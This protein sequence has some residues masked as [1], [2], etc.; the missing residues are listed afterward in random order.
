MPNLRNQLLVS[1]GDDSVSAGSS[2]M[3]ERESSINTST[4]DAE[5]GANVG[6]FLYTA[7]EGG[8]GTK[9]DMY[10]LGILL[11]EMCYRFSTKMERVI[12]LS[13]I[14]STE[15]YPPDF[16]K[17]EKFAI[18][19]KL[20]KWLLKRTPDDRPTAMELLNG[21]LMPA[22]AIQDNYIDKVSATLATPESAAFARLMDVLFNQ[23]AFHAT[24]QQPPTTP[25]KDSLRASA[26]SIAPPTPTSLSI[27]GQPQL[28]LAI[29]SFEELALRDS[30]IDDM[31]AVFKRHGAL[32]V[33]LPLLDR[34]LD[35]DSFVPFKDCAHVLFSSGTKMT[36]PYDLRLAFAKYASQV[37][38]EDSQYSVRSRT[39]ILKRYDSGAVYRKSEAGRHPKQFFLAD[40]DIVLDKTAFRVPPPRATMS[41]DLSLSPIPLAAMV[42][43]NSVFRSISHH[44][45]AHSG[46]GR[47]HAGSGPIHPVPVRPNGI[48][49]TMHHI[50]M[51]TASKPSAPD[52]ASATISSPPPVGSQFASQNNPDFSTSMPSDARFMQGSQMDTADR[53]PKSNG[54]VLAEAEL[55]RVA[56]EIMGKFKSQLPPFYIRINS[57]RI[58]EAIFDVCD[59]D[60]SSKA[61]QKMAAI[62]STAG[63]LPW[64][65]VQSQLVRDLALPEAKVEELRRF[66]QFKG[67]PKRVISQLGTHFSNFAKASPDAYVKAKRAISHLF[68]L[69][70]TL[71]EFS[72]DTS[73]VLLFDPALSLTGEYTSGIVFQVLLIMGDKKLNCIAVGGRYDAV[74]QSF[75]AHGRASLLASSGSGML[76]GSLVAPTPP[77]G[78]STTIFHKDVMRSPDVNGARTVAP[79][80]PPTIG[81]EAAPYPTAPAPHGNLC[82]VGI[83]FA[84]DKITVI[85]QKLAASRAIDS[86]PNGTSGIPPV[87]LNQADV[88][89]CSSGSLFSE[90]LNMVSQFWG[91]DVKTDYIYD[92]RVSIEEQERIAREN[93][94]RAVVRLRDLNF[95]TTGLVEIVDL[96]TRPGEA[97]MVHKNESGDFVRLLLARHRARSDGLPLPPL[98]HPFTADAQ[99]AQQQ[100]TSAAAKLSSS[101]SVTTVDSHFSRLPK[102]DQQLR[103]GYLTKL[104]VVHKPESSNPKPNS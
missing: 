27:S 10:S 77:P 35:W 29:P 68:R 81:G 7:P 90:R 73:Q 88:Y 82:A 26:S 1:L 13:Q 23:P 25:T 4:T 98:P 92:S 79:G 33:S 38:R 24:S 32:R 94:A 31:S 72:I 22:D 6:T 50:T 63:K 12:V 85:M 34:D 48:H 15:K 96:F 51:M 103:A 83:S 66:L 74:I 8:S 3:G 67:E 5:G 70:R 37:L 58:L 76:S 56:I 102:K 44:P 87:K 104:G 91:R 9:G 60:R 45:P 53:P 61:R 62:V 57:V 95:Y 100:P 46:G 28:S 49:Q 30:V 93:G 21:K 59:I 2:D 54:S 14:R 55:L 43:P 11:F 17:D 101:V 19:R 18:V 64:S 16:E 86:T 84:V 99:G 65:S 20:V 36:L 41:P 97:Y 89:V 40:F 69:L 42:D 39:S 75:T 71:E 78:G 80:S 47:P 52:L